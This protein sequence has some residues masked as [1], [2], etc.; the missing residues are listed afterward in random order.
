VLRANEQLGRVLDGLLPAPLRSRCVHAAGWSIVGSALLGMSNL[1]LWAICARVLG[2]L[3]FGE[4]SMGLSTAA[5]LAVLGGAGLGVTATKY[6]AELR[7]ADAT[8]AGRV[9]GLA[10]SV[11]VLSGTA[12][13]VLLALLAPRLALLLANPGLTPV[14]RIC[15]PLV[16]FGAV[17]SC[18]NGALAGF[19][20][21][22]AIARVNACSGAAS[23]PVIVLGAYYGGLRGAAWGMV[24]AQ[25]LNCTLSHVALRRECSAAGVAYSLSGA[26]SEAP[27]L[28]RFAIPAL[29]SATL[30]LPVMWISSAWLARQHG[31]AQLGLY[32]AADRW[33]L[34]ILFVP[35]CIFGTTLPILSNLRGAGDGQGYRSV[36]RTNVLLNA[37]LVVLPALAIAGLAKSMMS[38]FG[39]EYTTGWPVLSVLALGTASEAMNTTLGQPLITVSM[40]RRF[41]FDV[42]LATT[43]LF[44]SRMLIPHWGAMGL[45]LAYVSAFTTVAIA[46]YLYTRKR[47]F[48]EPVQ[49]ER[50]PACLEN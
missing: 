3:K 43:L 29:L 47:T 6:T 28:L 25:A 40:W 31:Y 36:F 33:R 23:F 50:E 34:A 16:C 11:V 39:G 7:H 41:G 22:R 37:G 38:I 4:L 5:V 32:A 13:S 9:L 17:N 42:L 19:E 14:L 1:V 20:A 15:V 35:T 21:F 10:C 27:I 44:A 12:M 8:R 24:V 26:W 46:L 18:Q 48:V 49:E 30:F 45:A 2:R